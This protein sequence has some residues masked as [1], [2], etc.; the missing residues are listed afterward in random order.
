MKSNRFNVH[1]ESVTKQ[2][3]DFHLKDINLSIKPGEIIG[4]IG[5]NGAGKTTLLK[6]ISQ[7]LSIDSGTINIPLKDNIGFVF[8]RNHLPNE[9]SAKNLDKIFRFTLKGWETKKF[10][11]YL[12]KFKIPTNLPLEKFSK[13]MSMKI[14]IAVVLSCNPKLLLLDEITS[15]LDPLI[16]DHVLNIIKEYTYENN[17]MVIMTTHILDDIIKIADRVVALREGTI[18]LNHKVK[19]DSVCN[20]EK[21]LRDSGR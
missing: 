6:V 12:S 13:G 3:G 18:F 21:M 9:L 7:N 5:E 8:D 15:G 1:V 4:V 2:L 19:N 16:R 11:A 10:Y 14:N 17:S 20:L